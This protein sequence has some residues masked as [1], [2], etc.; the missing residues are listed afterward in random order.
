VHGCNFNIALAVQSLQA[1]LL[2]L[3]VII[4]LFYITGWDI[5]PLHMPPA[6]L[7]CVRVSVTLHFDSV[8][9]LVSPS[10]ITYKYLCVLY[11]FRPFLCFQL[12]RLKYLSFFHFSVLHVRCASQG[13]KK[14]ETLAACANVIYLR[15]DQVSLMTLNATYLVLFVPIQHT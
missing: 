5:P 1:V 15:S 9:A 3:L 7:P 11:T 8:P 2:W 12:T 14:Q 10:S 13:Y 4:T 6:L